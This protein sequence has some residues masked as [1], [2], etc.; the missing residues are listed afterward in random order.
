[1]RMKQRTF[2]AAV[3]GTVVAIAAGFS[4]AAS[5]QGTNR[6]QLVSMMNQQCPTGYLRG[7]KWDG[8]RD[9][10]GGFAQGDPQLC[11]PASDNPPSVYQAISS[12]GT[13]I[14]P[15]VP[16]TQSDWCTNRVPHSSK[17]K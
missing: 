14:A 15:Y 13:C 9:G 12:G 16:D 10:Q 11:Y 5:A 4:I 2:I 1:M 17:A 7:Q 3:I 8:Q 6:V